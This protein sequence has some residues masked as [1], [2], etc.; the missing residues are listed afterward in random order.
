MENVWK[1]IR[2]GLRTLVRNPATTLLA[3]LTLALGI[4]ANS[5]IFSVVNRVLLEP[6]PYPQPDELVMLVESAPALGFPRFSVSPPNFEDFRRQSRSFEHLVAY[7]RERFNLTGREQPEAILGASVSP[8]FFQML[9]VDPSP[10]RGFRQEE[11]RPGQ[12]RV[13]VLSHGLW[14]RLFGGDPK[15]V[16]RPVTLNGESYTVVGI[17]PRGFELPRRAEIWVPLALDL[18]NENRGAHYLGAIGRLQ[19]GVSLEKAETEMIGIA[20]R[21]EKQ[22]PDS[23]SKWTVDLIPMKEIMVEDIRPVLMILLV[24]VAFVLLIAC[25]NVANLLLAR[26]ASRERE[27]AVRAALGASRSRLVRQMLVETAIL[28]VAGG[29][30]GLLLAHW[31]VKALVALDPEGIP[32]AREIGVDGRV[33][34]FTFLVSLATGVLFGLVPALSATGRRLYEALK[35]GGRAMAGGVHG[36]LMRNLL[37]GFEVAVALVLLVC[38]GLLIQSFARLSGVDPGFRSQGVLTARI[39]IPESKYPDEE[40]QALFY[41]RL[42]ERLAAIPGVE[43]AATIYPLP[44]G[45]SNMILTFVVEGRPVP[46]PAEA[47]NT[48]VRMISPDYFRVMGIPVIQ[49]RAFE[50]R[51]R[52]GAEEVVIVNQTLAARIW[53]GQSPIGKRFTFGDPA[54]SEDPGWRTVVGV[55]GDVRHDTLDQEK[56][57]EAYWPVAQGPATDTAL[58][59]RTS[60]DP[61]QLAAP[62][63]AAVRELDRDL[64]LE[65]IEPMEEVVSKA[66]AQS[67]FKTLLLSLFAGLALGLAAVGVYG[68]VSYSVAQR[69][70]EMGIRLALGA[71]P[72]QVQRMVLLQGMRVVLISSAVGIAAALFATRFLREQVYGVSATDP[73]TFL[74]VPLVLFS[75]AL[76]A[77]WVPALRATRVDPLEALR[78]E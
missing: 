73:A 55:V 53:P 56:A 54:D 64:P 46:P 57:S 23:N 3:M 13:A 49:G 11:G 45:G 43:G 34:A 60:G 1:D 6:L 2:F 50:P 25:A 35:E 59:L 61:V 44:L 5:A 8:D 19:R 16:G 33:L 68:V 24:A 18:A 48:N 28:F 36:R 9:R 71:R 66:L 72:G 22:Y 62:L 41:G 47:P 52:E 32:R 14:Q 74:I 4:G 38:A 63:R 40:R 70:H 42:L 29:A 21:L 75:V 77:N 76:L 10:G 78:Y 17:A 7:G 27:L 67:R 69:T 37:V 65:R 20:S 26:V 58:V 39:A 51:D 31:G 30:L 12:A 15:I